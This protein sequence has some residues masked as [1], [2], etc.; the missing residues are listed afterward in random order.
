MC[1]FEAL[2]LEVLCVCFVDMI[3][4][5]QLSQAIGQLAP[6]AHKNSNNFSKTPKLH[7]SPYQK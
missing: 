3:V 7:A 4:V 6:K 5:S 2:E 1:E